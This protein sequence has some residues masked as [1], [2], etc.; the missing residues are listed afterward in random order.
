MERESEV[1][2]E[3]VS[4]NREV[5]KV[6]RVSEVDMDNLAV[7]EDEAREEGEFLEKGSDADDSVA[8][9]ASVDEGRTIP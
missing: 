4:E 8:R 1:W 2:C 6:G 9:E 7:R 3:K 5:L